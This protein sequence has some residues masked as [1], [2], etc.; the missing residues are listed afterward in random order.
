MDGILTSICPTGFCRPPTRP[1]TLEN[2]ARRLYAERSSAISTR[3]RLFTTLLGMAKRLF[4]RA[5]PGFSA[6]RDSDN[7]GVKL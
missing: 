1:P 5:R 6:F 4:H 3:N 2:A 7:R